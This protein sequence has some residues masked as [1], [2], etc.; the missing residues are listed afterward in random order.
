VARVFFSYAGDDLSRAVEVFEWLSA[1]GHDVFF[2]RDVRN[3][4]PAGDVWKRPYRM[5]VEVPCGV[6]VGLAGFLA[7][8]PLPGIRRCSVG[9]VDNDAF[10]G[11]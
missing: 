3:G 5:L 11:P 10:W 8:L 2:D 4:I 6:L 9:E 7:M 1:D